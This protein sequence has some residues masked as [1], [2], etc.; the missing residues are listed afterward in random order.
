[1]K[2]IIALLFVA[3]ASLASAEC[4]ANVDIKPELDFAYDQLAAAKFPAD[5][6]A[7][8]TLMW[9]LWTK[10][11]DGKA[12]VL[13]NNGMA[14]LGRGEL[15]EA[16]MILTELVEYCPN[17]AEGWN[18]RAFTRYLARDFEGAIPDLERALEILPRHLGVISGKALTHMALD[19]MALAEIE[20]RKAIKLNPFS[21]ERRHIPQLGT[22]L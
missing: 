11:P 21:P 18:Q 7:I 14:L 13:L 3:N 1:M 16:E 2:Q 20:V 5:A 15:R 17:Y 6:Q 22:D 8:T 19:Q 10:A 9:G 4:P 12:Q